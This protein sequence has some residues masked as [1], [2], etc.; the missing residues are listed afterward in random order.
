MQSLL[1]WFSL[2]TWVLNPAVQFILFTLC[3]SQHR[4]L[5]SK[6]LFWH[7][8]HAYSYEISFCIQELE[9]ALLES[10]MAV[11]DHHTKLEKLRF[12]RIQIHQDLTD[13]QGFL[14]NFLLVISYILHSSMSDH[15]IHTWC[16][17]NWLY[18]LISCH[19]D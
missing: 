7:F 18:L 15:L 16:Y 10:G 9:D 1:P 4:Y 6:V 5:D 13:L 19:V 2:G 12:K 14:I 17:C 8:F 3:C 11:N